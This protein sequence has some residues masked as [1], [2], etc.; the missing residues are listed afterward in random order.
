M[1][2]QQSHPS[3]SQ[4]SP[5][6]VAVNVREPGER[7]LW[8]NGDFMKFWL[9]E[10]V[11]LFGS[12]VTLLALPLTAVLILGASPDQLGILRF[13]E[14]FPYILCPLLFGVWVDRARRRPLMILAN[15]VRAVLIGLVPLLAIFHQLFLFPAYA[16]TFGVGV[17]TVLFDVCWQSFVPVVVAQEHLIE[18][19]SKIST[20]S[21]AAEVGGPGLAGVLMQLLTAPLALVVDS[22]SY[23]VSV[24]SLLLIRK[25]EVLPEYDARVNLW[26]E[27]SEGLKF[28]FRHA[29]LRTLTLQAAAWNCCFFLAETIFL[30]YAPRVL[31]ISPGALG[32]LYAVSAVG[33]LVGAALA[34]PLAQ[35]FRLGWLLCCTFTLGTVPMLLLPAAVGSPEVI[36]LICGGGLFF[37]RTALGIWAVLTV[38]LRQAVTPNRLMGRVSACLRLVAYGGGAVGALLSGILGSTLGLRPGLWIGCIGLVCILIPIFFSPLPRL[39]AMP[40]REEE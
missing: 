22:L 1:S 27:M 33:G 31:H 15:S 10:T 39:R 24:V 9:G 7:S 32:L 21:A 13:L 29:I 37:V 35:H 25:P 5:L 16:I 38:S 34:R 40:E 30:L 18:A 23:V 28:S 2:A 20:S 14:T 12:Q 11:S 6:R 8:R 17:F 26:Q 19:N 3:T 4:D 36:L